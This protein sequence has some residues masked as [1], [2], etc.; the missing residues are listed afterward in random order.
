MHNSPGKSLSCIVSYT[1]DSYEKTIARNLYMGRSK[2]ASKSFM[3]SLKLIKEI[4]GMVKAVEAGTDEPGNTLYHCHYFIRPHRSSL[5]GGG[6]V[7]GA[8]LRCVA[9]PVPCRW[10]GR[11]RGMP[12][13]AAPPSI[14]LKLLPEAATHPF[15]SR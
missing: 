5:K 4:S 1:Q 7:L 13:E 8:V 10:W 9:S 11:G 3:F 6:V 2:D 14:G 12:L 15:P